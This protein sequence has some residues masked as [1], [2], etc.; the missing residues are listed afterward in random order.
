MATKYNSE[1]RVP[2][3]YPGKFNARENRLIS[4]N[5]AAIAS[6]ANDE[7]ISVAEDDSITHVIIGSTGCT[8]SLP[9]AELS[10]GRLLK[11]FVADEATSAILSQEAGS[12]TLSPG[13]YEILCYEYDGTPT[14]DIVSK[15]N[16][17]AP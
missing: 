16:F 5:Y 17:Y 9:K 14:F 4:H 7:T 2:S 8:V 1:G 6:S 12:A 10:L 13:T 3:R 15:S 11:I